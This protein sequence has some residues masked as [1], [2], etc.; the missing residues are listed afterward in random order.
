MRVTRVSYPYSSRSF[1]AISDISGL[2]TF[3]VLNLTAAQLR[4]FDAAFVNDLSTFS[5]KVVR[6]FA[7]LLQTTFA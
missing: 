2:L 1:C 3:S 5:H 4:P 7:M 6:T